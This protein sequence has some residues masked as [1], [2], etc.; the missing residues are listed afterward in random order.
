MDRPSSL[1][2]LLVEHSAEVRRAVV[3]WLTLKGYAVSTAVNG[4]D[5]LG[6]LRAGLKPCLILLDL[7]MPEMNGFEF[8]KR[9]LRDPQLARI[10]VVVYSGRY[11][12]HIAAEQLRATAYFFIPFGTDGLSRIIEVHCGRH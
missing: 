10:P 12:P 6:K 8:R 5:A 11:D 9:Q 4:V 2:V 7:H 1:P 3:E